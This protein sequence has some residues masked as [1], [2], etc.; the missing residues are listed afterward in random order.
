M[1][2]I[3]ELAELEDRS[4]PEDVAE[5]RHGREREQTGAEPARRRGDED[6]R[7]T[8]WI[9][10][11]AD[12]EEREDHARVAARDRERPDRELARGRRSPHRGHA[13]ERRH[14]DVGDELDLSRH[15]ADVERAR[16]LR[17]ERGAAADEDRE[18]H[19]DRSERREV[20]EHGVP[21]DERPPHR[22]DR[23]E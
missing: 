6:L 7:R 22:G 17:R 4:D 1:L 12:E 18:H 14:E 13:A 16:Y 10:G 3:G 9:G 20:H 23:E 15:D 21:G 5:D 2:G 19:R 11:P 8:E